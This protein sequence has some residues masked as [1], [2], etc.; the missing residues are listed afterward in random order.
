VINVGRVLLYLPSWIYTR[1]HTQERILIAVIN[2]TRDTL[3]KGVWSNIRKYMKE[4]FH[5]INVG[6]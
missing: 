6:C 5:D 3:I 2:V 4:L 1:E